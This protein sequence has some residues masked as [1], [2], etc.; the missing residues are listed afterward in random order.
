MILAVTKRWHLWRFRAAKWMLERVVLKVWGYLDR[1]VK[2]AS[3]DANDQHDKARLR[4]EV[5]KRCPAFNHKTM[6]CN[7]CG[8][9]MPAKVQLNGAKCPQGRWD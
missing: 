1:V 6:R 3:K 4:L 9:F 8:C 7:D 5:C 2:E